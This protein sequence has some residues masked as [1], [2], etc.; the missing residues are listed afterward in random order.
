M[1]V[2]E[3]LDSFEWEPESPRLD[4]TQP[5]PE[6]ADK[7]YVV[8]SGHQFTLKMLFLVVFVAGLS[9]GMIRWADYAMSTYKFSVAMTGTVTLAVVVGAA[10]GYII[11]IW[12]ANLHKKQ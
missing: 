8:A 2:S 9:L 4:A 11:G 1:C 3:D 10:A 5:A 7:R 12:I 6:H